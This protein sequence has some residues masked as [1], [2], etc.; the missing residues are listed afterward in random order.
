MPWGRSCDASGSCF[1]SGGAGVPCGRDARPARLAG[2][3]CARVDAGIARRTRDLPRASWRRTAAAGLWLAWV[4]CGLPASAQTPA[5]GREVVLAER[6]TRKTLTLAT[7]QPAR[8][9]PLARA[10]L[11][12]KLVAHVSEVLVDYGDRV[13]AG[14]LLVRLA[15]PEVDAQVARAQAE[16]VHARARVAQ[17]EAAQRS[18]QAA[19]ET[20]RAQMRQAS[21]AVARHEAELQRWKS[22]H[23]RTQQLAASGALSP[24]LVEEVQQK[25]LAAQAAVAEA[26]AA[27]ESAQA[28][29][30]EAEAQVLKAAA[31]VQAAAAQLQVA[32]ASLTQ[33]LASQS[34]LQITAP[35]EG[36]VVERR[37]DPGHLV[38]PGGPPLLTI[39]QVRT[40]RVWV[41]VPEM[42]APHVDVGDP[43]TLEVPALAGRAFPG[44]IS[45]TSFALADANR[46]LLAIADVD[47]PQ[48]LLRPGMY[49][50]ARIVLAQRADV[51]ALPLSAVVRQPKAAHCFRVVS[52]KAVQT[53]VELG[54]VTGEEVEIVA[55]V[56]E[57][58]LV[59][60]NKASMLADGQPIAVLPA[61]PK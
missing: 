31:D 23:A 58:D 22:E 53:P 56:S 55:G 60:M 61:K 44:T 20:A 30:Q 38:Q 50:T 33:A 7:T 10:P 3:G 12:S 4:A 35:F 52:G 41:A 24:Q 43:L 15:A 26:R 42:E 34:Y 2:I 16:V 28:H 59:V 14:Q 40:M 51:L 1:V 17:A 46:T 48:G 32:Q 27:V 49:A 39:A 54:L 6:P 19:V 8:I 18:A 9:E 13:E 36:V 25:H 37:V 5:S 47:N 21:A 11:A 29:H 57:Q 45:R